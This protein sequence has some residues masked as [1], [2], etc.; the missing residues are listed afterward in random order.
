LPV[1]VVD[2]EDTGVYDVNAAFKQVKHCSY[3]YMLV[4]YDVMLWVK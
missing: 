1:P 4:W 3:L 2:F